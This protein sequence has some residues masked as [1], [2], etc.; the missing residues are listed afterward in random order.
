MKWVLKRVNFYK[1]FSG[2]ET[3]ICMIWTGSDY[4]ANTVSLTHIFIPFHLPLQLDR[5]PKYIIH[6]YVRNVHNSRRACTALLLELITEGLV[7]G[8]SHLRTAPPP[9][10]HYLLTI[11]H[12]DQHPSIFRT[13]HLHFYRFVNS[14]EKSI[15]FNIFSP[16][17][18]I[19]HVKKYYTLFFTSTDP[20]GEF[21]RPEIVVSKNV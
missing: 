9:R 7:L 19:I 14:R 20:S 21:F 13:A 4:S 15:M 3:F 16:F 17:L 5:A 11:W 2:N 1:V 18:Q 6:L 8:F 10:V 12:A